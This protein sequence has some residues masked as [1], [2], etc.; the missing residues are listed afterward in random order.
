MSRELAD[1]CNIGDL[2]SICEQS[3][4]LR[5]LPN[6]DLAIFRRR[7]NDA[8]IEGVPLEGVSFLYKSAMFASRSYQSVS[9]T[10]AVCPRKSGIWS[11]ALPLSSKGM[12]ANAPPPEESQLTERYSGLTYSRLLV[13]A[14]RLSCGVELAVRV[15]PSR[16]WYPRH[17]G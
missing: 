2:L 14:H 3:E 15:P 10:V 5:N 1:R 13:S 11:G 4:P 9:R 12:T 7:G 6:E 8:I 16:G 17:C